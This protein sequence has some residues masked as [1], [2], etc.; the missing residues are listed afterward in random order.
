MF[1]ELNQWF[2]VIRSVIILAV[3]VAAALIIHYITFRVIT[4]FTGKSSKPL[5]DSVK[6]HCYSPAKGLA[7]FI[8]LR[9]VL[10]FL[11]IAVEIGQLTEF[12]QH[13]SSIAIIVFVCWSGIGFVFVLEDYVLSRFDIQEIDNLK[14]R[15]IYTQLHVI[16][17][18][19][20]AV[21][22]IL[23][24]ASAL[25]TFPKVQ[26]LGTTILA[27]AGVIGIVVGLAAQKTIGTFIAG[28]QI[29]VT[30]PIRI[31]DVVIVEGEWGRIEEITLTYVVV[32]IWDQRRL[33]LPITY[34]IDNPFQNWTRT[35]SDLLGTVYLYLDYRIPVDVIRTR[36]REILEES[37]KWD[38]KVC[39]VQVTDT[40]EKCVQVRALVSASDASLAW[41]LRCE[42]REKL[43]DFIAKN[44]PDS[45]PRV[46]ASLDKP[47]KEG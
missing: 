21:I 4:K 37:D 36:L 46:R 9:L 14:A 32:K 12:F 39:V 5:L 35:T 38:K 22:I 1:T 25:M 42:V 26:Q 16:T 17:R 23:G 33:V 20:T 11:E 19:T 43:V 45:L 3:A 47:E 18:I 28:L 7:V 13:F 6:K 24:I 2:P 44:Y 8:A 40:T 31:D 15:K 34:F 10:P 27:S 30:Q 29:A 41:G